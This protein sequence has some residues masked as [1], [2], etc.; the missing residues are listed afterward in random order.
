M[1]A[2]RV[3][4]LATAVVLAFAGVT[5]ADLITNGN[6]SA[7]NTGFNSG[8]QYVTTGGSGYAPSGGPYTLYDEGTYAIVNYDT[9]HPGFG[10]FMDADNNPN[11]RFMVV[12]GTTNGAG[13]AWGQNVALTAG[14]YNLSAFF[15][16][17][18]IPAADIQFRVFSGSTLVAQSNA[19]SSP[20]PTSP[21]GTLNGLNI[22]NWAQTA[23]NFSVTGGNYRVE[24]W[25]FDGTASGN[26]WAVDNISLTA[27]VPLP[28]AAYAGLA[29]LAGIGAFGAIRRKRLARA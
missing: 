11:G 6:F 1:N 5:S 19:F 27:V 7:G 10:D 17:L 12:N 25:D 8:Y 21:N 18:V 24:I 26:D 20:V 22:G 3:S 14:S 9:L 28:P 13:P 16:T 23:F 29:S 2:S 4:S 15:A